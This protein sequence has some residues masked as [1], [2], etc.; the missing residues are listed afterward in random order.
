MDSGA[1]LLITLSLRVLVHAAPCQCNEPTERASMTQ[2]WFNPLQ[3]DVVV[4]F[5]G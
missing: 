3:G 4:N 2:L 5:I 1:Q